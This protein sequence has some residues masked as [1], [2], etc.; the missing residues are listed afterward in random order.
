MASITTTEPALLRLLQLSSPALP[1]G[2][3]AFSQGLEYAIEAQWLCN[4]GD[5][6]RWLMLQL[7]HG[8][9][10]VDLVLLKRLLQAW[11]DE[12]PDAVRYWNA[13]VLA[14]R[15]TAEFRNAELA[16]GEA[17]HRL[18]PALGLVVPA[19]PVGPSYVAIFAAVAHQWQLDFKLAAF[20]YTWGWLENQVGAATKLLPMGQN[21]AQGLLVA[22]QALVPDCITAAACDPEQEPGAGLPAT[23]IAS[24]L[25]ESQYSRLFR[26]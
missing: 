10:K 7:R 8:V 12:D 20:A 4:A 9:T 22:M 25:H 6:E 5:V 19:G 2:A 24:C 21:T 11:Q 1:V 17:L 14:C 23:A 13:M 15:E 26:S 16:M 3:Y 18:L